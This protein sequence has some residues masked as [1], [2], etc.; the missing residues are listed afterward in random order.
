MSEIRFDGRVAI[1][2]GAGNG[3][4]KSHAI[5]LAKRGARVVINDIGASVDGH[6]ESSE[7]STEVAIQIKQLGGD[8]ITHNADV[9][10]ES[11][12]ADMVSTVMKCWGR[13]D[14][15]VNNA[16]YLRDKSFSKMSMDDFRSIVNVHLI[17]SAI[18]AKAVWP[19]MI[20]QKYGRIVMTSS[21]SGL[22]GNFGQANYSAAKMGVVG[23][24]N[25]LHLE[26]EKHNVR[27][28]CLAPTAGTRMLDGLLPQ[29]ILELMTVESVSA[30]LLT[31]V[32]EEGPSRVILCAG[33]G[34][35]A[36]TRIY[37]TDGV[38]LSPEQ[39]T[40]ELVR[41]AFDNVTDETTQKQFFNGAEQ[42]KKFVKRA[43]QSAGVEVNF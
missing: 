13:I 33:A 9:T 42:T 3:L 30:G 39:Q 32:D 26:G 19:H 21:S 11:E 25:T 2:T 34:G 43:A 36:Q 16:G 28:S 37:E 41:A 5:A 22:Y 6:N 24:M 4:G 10:K 15:L 12:V 17:G 7:A 40:P 27:V 8:A 31:L 18:C 35:Y 29:E 1:V 20:E 38:H 23:L 14:I